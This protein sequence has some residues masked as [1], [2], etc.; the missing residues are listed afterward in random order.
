MNDERL[1]P[2]TLRCS[3]HSSS[4]KQ[5]MKTQHNEGGDRRCD[6]ECCRRQGTGRLNHNMKG[7]KVEQATLQNARVG[8]AMNLST[9]ALEEYCHKGD[10]RAF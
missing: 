9:E 3:K 2:K 5:S 6:L 4:K 1:K 8:S 10:S 7:L